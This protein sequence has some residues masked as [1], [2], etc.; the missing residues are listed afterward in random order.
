MLTVEYF[1][2]NPFQENTYIVYDDEKNCI[3]IDPGCSNTFE[4]EELS[5]FISEN[6]L[7]PSCIFLTHSHID[8]VYGL[9]YVKSK[10]QVPIVGH[11]LAN[12]GI[13]STQLVANLYG[14]NVTTPPDLDQTVDES[15][16]VKIG[17]TEMKLL[18][19]PGH[20]PD[21]LV[22]YNEKNGFAI[23]GDVIFKESIGRTDLP[24]GNYETLMESIHQKILLLPSNTILYPGHGPETT[25]KQEITNNPF[26][27]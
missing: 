7:K 20:S 26:L 1:T 11:A 15:D 6:Q 17:Q 22:L 9:A 23:V 24:G 13:A 25:I 10:Y 12:K 27:K 21:H 18:F 4:E 2:F 14:L 16:M 3:I 5:I 8:H 19:C